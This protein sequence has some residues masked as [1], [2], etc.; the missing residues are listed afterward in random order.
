MTLVPLIAQGRVPEGQIVIEC[1][2]SPGGASWLSKRRARLRQKRRPTFV[3]SR[4]PA[5]FR[6]GELREPLIL[7][8]RHLRREHMA[9]WNSALKG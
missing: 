8:P 6:R 9:S 4:P 3:T 7:P 2:R 5:F 1:L